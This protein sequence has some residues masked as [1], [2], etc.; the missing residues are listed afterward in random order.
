MSETSKTILFVLRHAH[1]AKGLPG[2]ADYDRALDERGHREGETMR[3]AMEARGLRPARVLC[4]GAARTRQT[5]GLVEGAFPCAAT[6]F[7]DEIYFGDE[8]VYLRKAREAGDAPSLMLV[9]HNPM[10]AD[11]VALLA[12][13]GD[14]EAMRHLAE[15]FPPG[16]LAILEFA[17]PLSEIREGSGVLTAQLEPRR[18]A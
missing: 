11:L 12:G 16:T 15:G 17:T 2:Q 13:R 5:L 8:R 14:D 7:T 6:E 10:M 9:G 1:A 18:L 4:S 3:R